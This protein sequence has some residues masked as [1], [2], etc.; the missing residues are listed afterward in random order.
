[1]DS[2]VL[3]PDSQAGGSQLCP[4]LKTSLS[5]RELPRQGTCTE[6]SVCLFHNVW[7]LSEEDLK[8]GRE[9]VA[10][11][12]GRVEASP[13]IGLKVKASCWL[14]PWLDCQLEHVHCGFSI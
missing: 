2:G 10:E 12:W 7:G 4:S 3:Y 1:M 5:P 9:S 6:D 11:V 13:L 14:R 8:I